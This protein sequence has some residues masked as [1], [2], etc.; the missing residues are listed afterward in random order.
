MGEAKKNQRNA[1][2]TTVLHLNKFAPGVAEV[3]LGAKPELEDTATIFIR[4]AAAEA[5]SQSAQPVIAPQAGN[6]LSA[7]E[8]LGAVAYCY[9]KGVF[10]SEEIERNMLKDSEL[11]AATR[12]EIP[13]ANSIRRFRK[14]NRAAI[15]ATLEKWYRK[16]R[17][18]K[19]PTEVMPG[20]LPPESTPVLSRAGGDQTEHTTMYARR[21]AT[22][23][24]NKAA[25]I[26][27]M[28]KEG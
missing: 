12:G 19:I 26:D 15:Q 28:S 1:E 24:L 13:D 9:A 22:E 5:A 17:K 7:K 6:A 21:E 3:P 14:V 2:E 8:M 25:F 23:R 11:R 20:A 16:L 10:T 4:K 27:N 18:Q